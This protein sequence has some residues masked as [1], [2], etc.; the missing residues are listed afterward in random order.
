MRRAVICMMLACSLTLPRMLQAQ[1]PIPPS[2]FVTSSGCCLT[3]Y[4][5]LTGAQIRVPD[6]GSLGVYAMTVGPNGNLFITNSA[7]I[8]EFSGQT[9]AV[10][11]TFIAPGSGGMDVPRALAFGPDGNLYVLSD[12]PASVLEFNGATGAF[13]GTFVGAET[14]PGSLGTVYGNGMTF[15]P[16]GDLFI[17]NTF[18]NGGGGS[19]VLEFNGSTGA[20]VQTLTGGLAFTAEQLIFGPGGILY[21]ANNSA[22]CPAMGNPAGGVLTYGGAGFVDFTSCSLANEPVGLQFGPDGNLYVAMLGSSNVLKFNGSTGAFMSV[23]ANSSP[24]TVDLAFTPGLSATA[25]LFGSAGGSS[26]VQLLTGQPWTATS[27]SSFLHISSGSA[28]GTSGGPVFFTCDPFTGTGSRTGTLTIAGLTVTVTQAGTNYTGTGPVTVP[29]GSSF[30]GAAGTPVA[31]DTAGNVYAATTTGL[32]EWSAATQQVNA[33]V[34]SG[35][36]FPSG[37]AVDGSDNVYIAGGGDNTI[38]EWNS[39]TQQLTTLASSVCGN[40]D[41]PDELAIDG[42]GNLYVTCPISQTIGEWSPLT[43]QVSTLLSAA[44]LTPNGVAVDS[45]F[46]VYFAETGP[47]PSGSTLAK[48]SPSTQQVTTLVPVSAGLSLPSG[49]AVDGFGNVYIADLRNYTLWKWNVSTQQLTTLLTSSSSVEPVSVAVDGSGNLY[50]GGDEVPGFVEIPNAFVGPASLNELSPAGSDA[51]LPV[52]SL[53]PISL[54]GVFA[55]TSSQSWLTIGTITNEAVDFSFT[56][57]RSD[58]P[59]AASINIL[60]QQIAVTQAA[61]LTTLTPALLAF[62]Y[63]AIGDPSVS[64][65]TVFE[66]SE[67]TGIKISSI[68]VGGVN[69]GD[70]TLGGNC[71][72]ILGKGKSCNITVTFTPSVLGDESAI[73][74]VASSSPTSPQYASLTGIGMAPVALSATSLHLGAVAEGNTSAQ[75]TVTLTNRENFALNFTSILTSAG[76]AISSNTCGTSVAAKTT[77]TVGVT[78]SPSV[79]GAATGTLTF[80]DNAESSPQTVNLYGDGITPVSLSVGILYLGEVQVGK[81]SAAQNVTLTNHQNVALSF[82]SILGSAGFEISSNSCSGSLAAGGTCVVGV[83]FSPTVKGAASGTLTFTDNAENSPQTVTLKG[84]GE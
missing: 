80:T 41:F 5:G 78:F 24:L 66:N 12:G 14:G 11:G 64:K 60:G 82:T 76:F 58:S 68:A 19:N 71:P 10:I 38:K 55:P 22:S 34:L 29:L 17:S 50:V 9:G 56:P 33:L 2:M 7:G 59:R 36:S 45:L 18:P 30:D 73:L 75:Q 81:T 53:S 65:T 43:Q 70:F 35:L 32:Y 27:N 61:S 74:A 26:S 84:T 1:G 3:Q 77:C 20:Y 47:L 15:G 83:T 39:S 6:T 37:L 13:I 51:L 44:P 42:A 40:S 31:V 4:N 79:L 25:E 67:S 16:N 69:P 23:F 54:S 46:N 8:Q 21:V 63:E 57:N 72:T 48:W 49:L 62:S 52:V 28:S